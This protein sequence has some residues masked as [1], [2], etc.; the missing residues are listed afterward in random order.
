MAFFNRKHDN[1][2]ANKLRSM[3]VPALGTFDYDGKQINPVKFV[4]ANKSNYMLLWSNYDLTQCISRYVWEN[5]PD[6]IKS[7]DLERMLYYRTSLTGFKF[8][9]HI[10]ILPY[11]ITGGLNPYGYPITGKP[12]TY[13]G[14]PI[15]DNNGNDIFNYD[16]KFNASGVPDGEYNA[17]LLFDSVPRFA[18]S[19]MGISRFQLNQ[20]IIS[21]MAEVLARININVIVTNKKLFFVAKDA[22]QKSVIEREIQQ[23][24]GSDAPFD[25]ITSP[26]EI[27]TIQNTNDYQADDL[28]NVLKN[29]DAIRCFMSGIQSKNFGTEKKERLVSGELAGNEEQIDLVADIGL[30]LRQNFANNMN[31]LFG[32][33]IKVHKRADEYED[34]VD[35]RNLTKLDEEGNL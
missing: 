5:L 29:Y 33:N 28:F 11:T 16:L 26:L 22:N 7:Y 19:N 6:N 34:E 10:M 21:N 18:G 12:L 24:L 23:F 35:G 1:S 9:G 15:S 17:I 20:I 31:K 4:N 8:A 14:K 25:V 13:N 27:Q 30:E 3:G 32:T 2:Q